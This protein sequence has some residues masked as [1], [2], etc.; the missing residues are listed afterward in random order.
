MAKYL[1]TLFTVIKTL[2]YILIILKNND[3]TFHIL[4]A[5]IFFVSFAILSVI[6]ILESIFT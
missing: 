1:F 5:C 6:L 2:T 3:L 4:N